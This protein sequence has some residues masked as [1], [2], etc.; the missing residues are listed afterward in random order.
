MPDESYAR[1]DHAKIFLAVK[2]SRFVPANLEEALGILDAT[3][4]YNDRDAIL[5]GL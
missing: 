4:R 1:T 3:A 5:W 2:A